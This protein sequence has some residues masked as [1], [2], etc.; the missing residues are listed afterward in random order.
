VNVPDAR[1]AGVGGNGE[2]ARP[3]IEV[4]RVEKSRE[5]DFFLSFWCYLHLLNSQR[6]LKPKTRT[7]R[8]RAHVFRF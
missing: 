4:R 7:R 5:S 1:E 3:W 6:K 2:R 8:S